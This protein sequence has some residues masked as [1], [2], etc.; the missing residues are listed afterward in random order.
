MH[1]DETA[2][3]NGEIS[4]ISDARIPVHDHGFLYGDGVYETIRTYDKRPF[5]L[6][7]HLGRLERSAAAIRLR[8][9][10]EPPRIAAEIGRTLEA[11]RRASGDTAAA[12]GAEYA[13]RVMATRG[14]GALGYDPDLCPEPSLMILVT[15]LN[16]MS[17]QHREEGIHAVIATV[18]RN[19]IEA[20]DPRV[21]SLNLLN[22]ILA[23]HVAKDAGAHE[24]ILFNTAGYLAEGTLT[25]VF[26]VKDARV[27]TPS[28]DCGILSGITRDIVLQILRSEGRPSVEGRFTREQ[29]LA[30][31]EVFLTSTTREVFPVALLDGR[32][33]G[34]G[35]RG[36]VTEEL[37]RLFG[38]RVKE[39][40]AG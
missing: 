8:L 38:R 40:M 26:F 11:A 27:M 30:A 17:R 39:I 14:E 23:S 5:C 7:E 36:P 28:L 19:P 12:P 35:A 24:A 18:R 20:L 29:L 25:N 3:I 4:P 9:K 16:A 34:L 21:K 6:G 2:N 31:D 37:Q 15:R 13:I 32:P 1:P 10:W 33:V 22:N